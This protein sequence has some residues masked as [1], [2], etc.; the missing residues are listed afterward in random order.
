[1][2]S[3]ALSTLTL[4]ATRSEAG[5][6]SETSARFVLKVEQKRRNIHQCDKRNGENGSDALVIC[7]PRHLKPSTEIWWKN[8]PSLLGVGAWFRKHWKRSP[9]GFY[10]RPVLSVMYLQ[11][12]GDPNNVVLQN[13]WKF[14]CCFGLEQTR[15]SRVTERW[16]PQ[17]RRAKRCSRSNGHNEAQPAACPKLLREGILSLHSFVS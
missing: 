1:M 11:A 17:L 13:L 12:P 7:H 3:Q 6:C 8:S 2:I 16:K 4:E 15:H 10:S 9:V 5:S 14:W